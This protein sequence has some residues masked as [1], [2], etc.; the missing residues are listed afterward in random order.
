[1]FKSLWLALWYLQ[2]NL[3]PTE[4]IA[5]LTI[6]KTFDESLLLKESKES[7]FSLKGATVELG[8]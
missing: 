3:F 8:R 2:P 1:M 4:T 6:D 5:G 7:I